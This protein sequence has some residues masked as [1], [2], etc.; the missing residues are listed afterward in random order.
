L[1]TTQTEI[2]TL[3][4]NKIEAWNVQD[5]LPKLR[6]TMASLQSSLESQAITK[7]KTNVY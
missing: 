1:I 4:R 2:K 7:P 3:L 6:I 5:I